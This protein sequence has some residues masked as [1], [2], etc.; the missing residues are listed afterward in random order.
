M[1]K[2]V[3][4]CCKFVKLRHINGSGPGFFETH[5]RSITLVRKQSCNLRMKLHAACASVNDCHFAVGKLKRDINCLANSLLDSIFAA[6]MRGPK[7][8]MPVFMQ[9]LPVN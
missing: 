8:G 9:K 5:C 7:H 2:I 6:C 4:E 1:P 3:S